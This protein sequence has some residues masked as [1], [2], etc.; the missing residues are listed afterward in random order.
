[1]TALETYHFEVHYNRDF[2]FST[3][4]FKIVEIERQSMRGVPKIV[5]PSIRGI[6][7]KN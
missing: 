2:L 4:P 7:I 3:E 6:A 5:R 1:M